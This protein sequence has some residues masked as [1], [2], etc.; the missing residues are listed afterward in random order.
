MITQQ[1]TPFFSAIEADVV[2]NFFRE[3]EKSFQ[4]GFDENEFENM[5]NPSIVLNKY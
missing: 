2:D 5:Q 1:K 4:I 3:I